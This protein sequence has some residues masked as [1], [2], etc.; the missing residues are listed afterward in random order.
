MTHIKWHE[1]VVAAVTASLIV[2]AVAGCV[3][4]PTERA[5]V[6]DM[7]PQLSF[8]AS[9]PSLMATRVFV[10]GLDMGVAG[11]YAEGVAALRLIPGTHVVRLAGPGSFVSEE[12]VFLTDGV[13]RT[14]VVGGG[15]Q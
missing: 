10:D 15:N 12:R 11:D 9:N 4:M 13:Q 1:R 7:R 5:H 8:K 6:P 14:I 3:Q 2:I